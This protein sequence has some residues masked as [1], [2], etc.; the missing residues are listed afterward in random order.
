[1]RLACFDQHWSSSGVCKI[2]D[3]ISVLPSVSS[4]FAPVC[5]I[6][7]GIS[8]YC[9]VCSCGL[10]VSCSAIIGIVTSIPITSRALNTG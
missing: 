5:H 8:S 3:E 1:M 2:A 4:G 9:V 10:Y 7:M 6:V